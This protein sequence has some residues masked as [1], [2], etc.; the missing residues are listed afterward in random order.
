MTAS[1]Q[2]VGN[3][4]HIFIRYKDG[5]GMWRTKSKSTG[6][7]VSGHNKRKAEA[8]RDKI[9]QEMEKNV[10]Y[11]SDT[12]ISDYLTVWLNE[13]RSTVQPNTYRG[14]ATNLEKHAI[15]YFTEHK[16]KL[17]ELKPYHLETYY[18]EMLTKGLS[19]QT[20]RHHHANLSK[21][22]TDAVKRELVPNNP[23]LVANPPKV[24]KYRAGF[25]SIEQERQLLEIAKDSVL[26]IPILLACCYGLRRSEVLG[27]AWDCVDFENK[28]LTVS[29]TMLQHPGGDYI[30]NGTKNDSSYRTLPLYDHV[31]S[32]LTAHK[33]QQSIRKEKLGVRYHDSNFVCTLPNGTPIKP[34]YLTKNYKKLLKKGGLPNVRFHDLRHSMASNL[35]ANGRSVV[36]VQEWLGHANASTTLNFYSHINS[37]KAKADIGAVLDSLLFKNESVVDSFEIA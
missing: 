22:L 14:Y 28:K 31:L 1:L 15:P 25:L 7:K 3:Y 20:V 35:L 27:L 33:Q 2:T 4:Y 29:Q 9:L 21:A 12:Y 10:G 37:D 17:I 34:N 26:Y 13:I 11:D 19:P 36:E 32:A 30:R 18:R 24:E 16:I 5:N 8:M 23:A 6:L